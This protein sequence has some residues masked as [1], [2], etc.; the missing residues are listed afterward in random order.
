MPGANAAFFLWINLGK[1]FVENADGKELPEGVVIE[2]KQAHKI[3]QVIFE[4][5]MEKKVFL[6]LG[7]A[8][9]AEEPGWFRLVFTQAPE[10]IEEG[11]KRI[12]QAL[13]L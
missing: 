4:R 5:L 3:T 10:L 12:A 2:G 7:D 11:V 13:E 8:T 1:K 9:G 6:V